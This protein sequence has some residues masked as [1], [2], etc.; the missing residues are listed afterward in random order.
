VTILDYKTGRIHDDPEEYLK[1]VRAGEEAQ[2]ALYYAM[3]RA[4]GDDVARVALVSIR[5]ARDKTWVLALDIAGD[6]GRAVVERSDRAGVVRATCSTSDLE[7]SLDAL[8][9]RCDEITREGFDHFAV[10]DDPPCS[11]CSYFAACRERP[12][13]AERIFAR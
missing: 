8:T 11:Y 6:G 4:R 13:D 12:A 7:R 9:R 10:G 2:L 5:D 3:R 1:L